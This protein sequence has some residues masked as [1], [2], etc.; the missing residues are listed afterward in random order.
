MFCRASLRAS[1]RQTRVDMQRAAAGLRLGY[2]Y[3]A[4][5]LPQY[6]NRGFVQAREAD[7]GHA[8]AHKRDAVPCFPSAASVLP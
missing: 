7:V 8:A 4:A 2:R 1:S 6:A 5:I 3:F